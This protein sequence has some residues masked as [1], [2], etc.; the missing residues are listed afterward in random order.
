MTSRPQILSLFELGYSIF[1]IE[2]LLSEPDLL[3][4]RLCG[5][6]E[7]PDFSFYK[8]SFSQAVDEY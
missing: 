6:V 4:E 2:E 3:R 5:Y 1:E 7:E 8:S